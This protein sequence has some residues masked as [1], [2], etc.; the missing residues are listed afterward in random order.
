MRVE[1]GVIELLS[2]EETRHCYCSCSDRGSYQ[3][4]PDDHVFCEFNMELDSKSENGS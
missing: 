4:P 3:E 1:D 2:A